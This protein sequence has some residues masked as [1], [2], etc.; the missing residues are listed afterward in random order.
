MLYNGSVFRLAGNMAVDF[1]HTDLHDT[2]LAH[3]F[4]TT[5]HTSTGV[6][7]P[8]VRAQATIVLV[9]S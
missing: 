1:C 6:H 2:E 7:R 3:S 9:W 5:L 4:S 8:A